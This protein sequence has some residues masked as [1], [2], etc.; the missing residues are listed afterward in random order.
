MVSVSCM[1]KLT[2]ALPTNREFVPCLIHSSE[3]RSFSVYSLSGIVFGTLILDELSLGIEEALSAETN[4]SNC[5]TVAF[6]TSRE[7]PAEMNSCL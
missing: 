1:K 2:T 3:R 5:L 4:Q 7:V 6:I